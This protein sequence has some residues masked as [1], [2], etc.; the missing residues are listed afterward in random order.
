MR[1][2][3]VLTSLLVIST[4]VVSVADAD[5]AGE[6]LTVR[7]VVVFEGSSYDT[8]LNSR[9]RIESTLP[10]SIAG[11][12]PTSTKYE[13]PIPIGLI[14]F[15]GPPTQ[16]FDVLI[17]YSGRAMTHFPAASARSKRLLWGRLK[18]TTD[19]QATSAPLP[20][21]H[22][23]GAINFED[24]LWVSSPSSGG[25]KF[26]LYD[27]EHKEKPLAT[28]DVSGE[29]WSVKNT[30]R[31][32]IHHA[33]IF[34]PTSNGQFQLA[35]VETVEGY[36]PNQA[37]S[38][39]DSKEQKQSESK[40]DPEA[41][42]AVGNVLGGLLNAV[43]GT[44]Q[45]DAK[46]AATVTTAKSDLA[47]GKGALAEATFGAPADGIDV[48]AEYVAMLPD[49]GEPEQ[50]YLRA[51]LASRALSSSSATIVYGLDI[52]TLSRI[53]PIEVTP[54]PDRLTRTALVLVPDADPSLS[55]QVDRLIAQLGD[56][57]WQKREEA[58]DR[59]RDL[60]RITQ[61]NLKAASGHSDY[62]IRDRAKRLLEELTAIKP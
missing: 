56:D 45:K 60:G 13:S 53:Q 14:T 7:D 15:D 28:I 40:P 48:V 2:I 58:E 37:A 44:P 18:A 22:W 11:R 55:R 42:K 8:V 30:G 61:R 6:Q 50:Q 5:D 23:L 34:R 21:G 38:G 33:V 62:E 3:V 24:R 57:S 20:P 27:I 1:T 36:R 43:T 32:P 46:P 25:A 52:K 59:L 12:R 16:D 29:T 47:T 10:R 39:E 41:V 19:S 17:E 26:I 51:L 35:Y 31:D 9:A 54:Q 4:S 49:L